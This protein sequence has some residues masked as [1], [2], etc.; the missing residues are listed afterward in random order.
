M[1]GNINKQGFPESSEPYPICSTEVGIPSCNT[2]KTETGY[3]FHVPQQVFN[4]GSNRFS[5]SVIFDDDQTERIYVASWLIH[6]K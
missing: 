6:V 4:L 3:A 2:I 1:N 5:I